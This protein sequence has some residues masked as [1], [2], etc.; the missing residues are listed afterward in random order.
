[1]GRYHCY[2]TASAPVTSGKHF[3][4]HNLPQYL[5]SYTPWRS[6]QVTGP[7]CIKLASPTY[8]PDTPLTP[9]WHTLVCSAVPFTVDGRSYG[10]ASLSTST[11]NMSSHSANIAY[12]PSLDPMTFHHVP[13]VLYDDRTSLQSSDKRAYAVNA[14]IDAKARILVG[15]GALP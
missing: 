3:F 1:M 11:T 4:G 9:L 10:S 5:A 6:T 15:R 7:G 14:Q 12:S 13:A 2:G 8:A